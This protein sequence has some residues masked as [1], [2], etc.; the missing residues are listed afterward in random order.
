MPLA[1]PIGSR[2]VCTVRLGAITTDGKTWPD[3]VGLLLLLEPRPLT[4]TRGA[5]V[6][7]RHVVINVPAGYLQCMRT[8]LGGRSYTCKV[9]ICT[10]STL[11]YLSEHRML[12]VSC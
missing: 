3:L 8:G 1:F 2:A 12:T 9:A 11:P 10:A 7:H 4:F 5:A 6:E